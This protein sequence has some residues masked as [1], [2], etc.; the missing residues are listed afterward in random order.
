MRKL[1]HNRFAHIVLHQYEPANGITKV[2]ALFRTEE[3]S[4]SYPIKNFYS[5][6]R[7]GRPEDH[8]TQGVPKKLLTESCWGPKILTKIEH[9]GA[10][11]LT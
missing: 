10:M 6:G 4:Q 1:K 5:S 3:L 9:S 2:K 7:S 11:D 8:Y